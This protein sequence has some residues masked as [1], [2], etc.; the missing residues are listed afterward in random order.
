[1][2][3]RE[4]GAKATHV[5]VERQPCTTIT[6]IGTVFLQDREIHTYWCCEHKEISILG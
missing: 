1:M 4:C 3:C 2:N 6:R 5:H